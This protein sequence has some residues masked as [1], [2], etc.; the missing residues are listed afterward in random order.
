MKLFGWIGPIWAG[1][2]LIRGVAVLAY[3]TSTVTS[4]MTTIV[5]IDRISGLSD[6]PGKAV[7]VLTG[8]NAEDFGAE[9]GLSTV[10]FANMDTATE[11]L[12][13]GWIDATVGDAPVLDYFAYKNPD[14]DVA[15]VG[16]L[17]EPTSTILALQT[18]AH[19]R[20]R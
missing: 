20:G 8:S 13:G 9:T 19:S 2:W 18:A 3:V 6:L 7:G 1:L 11:A 10:S 12:I 16:D 17:F 5:L 14:R 15:V 4:V